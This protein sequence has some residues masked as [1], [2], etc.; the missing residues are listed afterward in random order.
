MN[1][2]ER[3]EKSAGAAELAK[4]LASE[5][6]AAASEKVQEKLDEQ[7]QDGAAYLD[8]VAETIRR[9]ARDLEKDAPIA[10]GIA[11]FCA[12][13]LE[14]YAGTVE[15]KSAAELLEGVKDFTRNQPVIVVAAAAAVGFLVFRAFRNAQ[16]AIDEEDAVDEEFAGA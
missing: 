9:A 2:G 4:G 1:K 3:T 6:Y 13:R 10:S 12:D 7:V 5:A 15:G 8:T 14:D 11:D 16:P